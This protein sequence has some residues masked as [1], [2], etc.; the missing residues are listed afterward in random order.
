MA[1]IVFYPLAQAFYRTFTDID[2]P[3]MGTS[4]KAH[5]GCSSASQNYIDV[6]TARTGVPAGLLLDDRLDGRQRLLPLHA[7]PAASQSSSTRGSAGG[8]RSG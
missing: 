6:L 3:N 7:R 2:A 8:R 5:P 1:V 4:F